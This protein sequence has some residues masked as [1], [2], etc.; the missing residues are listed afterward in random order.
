MSD[1]RSQDTTDSPDVAGSGDDRWATVKKW[2]LRIV[3]VTLVVLAG[4]YMGPRLIYSFS[5]ESTDDAYVGGTI[6]PISAQVAGKVVR[7]FVG[8]HETV[9]EGQPLLAIDP[10]DYRNAVDSRS[11][12][13]ASAKAQKRATEASL[14]EQRRALAAA[15]ADLGAATAQ[16]SLATREKDRYARLLAAGSVSQ[17]LFDHK[18]SAWKVAEARLQVARASVD[19]AGATIRRLKAQIQLES[20]QIDQARSALEDARVKLGRT[21]L[22]APAPGVLAQKSV[23]PGQIVQPGQPLLKLV[24][25]DSM[26]VDANFKETQLHDIRVGQKVEIDI[27]A[28]PGTSFRGHVASFQ[29]GTGAVFSLLPPENATGNFVKVVRRVPVRIWID[30]EADPSHPLW[31]GLSAVPH[32]E[33]G[34]SP[35]DAGAPVASQMGTGRGDGPRQ[36]G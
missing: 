2:A 28:Y 30:S 14:E 31:P 12:A 33:T 20:D 35:D 7:V 27:D 21:T 8:D 5:H 18:Q 4:A 19:R 32:V 24:R 6:V 16:D 9:R 10:T 17:S 23:D 26:Y 34:S 1:E 22:T 3:P 11:A 25:R 13:L 15:R 36:G 29:P